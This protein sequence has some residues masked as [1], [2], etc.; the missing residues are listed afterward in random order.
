MT[1]ADQV[2]VAGQALPVFDVQ[3]PLL[4]LPGI[5]GTT[6]ATIPGVVPYLQADQSLLA[7]WRE[8]LSPLGGFKIGISWQGNPTF[9]GDSSRSVPLCHFEKLARLPGVHLVS[10]QK[11][12]GLE[13]LPAFAQ[14]YPVLDLSA[15]LV[16]FDDTAAV[17]KNMDLVISSCTAIPHLAGALA[18]PVWTALQ[19]VPDWRWHLERPDSPWYPTMRLFRQQ[20]PGAWDDVF[21]AMASRLALQAK[22]GVTDPPQ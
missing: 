2:V 8:E 20:R 19:F 13:Q 4:S 1:G 3:V 18:L 11:G 16:T 22:Y 9:R 15:R 6:L 14:K 5:F 17:M 10:L 21:E 12:P 7:A